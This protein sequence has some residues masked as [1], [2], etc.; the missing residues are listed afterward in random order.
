MSE[1][2]TGSQALMAQ[3]SAEG[4]EHVLTI[5]GEQS[6]PLCETMREYSQMQYLIGRHEHSLAFIANG[7]ARASN[8][9][10][11]PIVVSGPGVTDSLTPLGDA[12]QDSVPMVLVCTR[13]ENEQIGKGVL[14][15]LKD[16]S[17]LLS[18]IVKWAA[19]AESVQEVPEAVR[20]AFVQAYVGRPGP[21]VVEIPYNVQTE[22]GYVDIYPSERPAPGAADETMV[23]GVA[24]LLSRAKSPLIYAGRGAALS[25]CSDELLELVELLH[26]P[27]ITTVLGKGVLPEA[28]PLNVS[29]GSGRHGLIAQYVADA[30]TV[31]V[32][33]SSLDYSDAERFKLEFPAHLIQIDT[34]AESIGR[35]YPAEIGLIGDART[36]L[37]QLLRELKRQAQLPPP[38]MAASFSEY[39]KRKIEELR[40]AAAWQYM[41]AIQQAVSPETLIF[42][43]PARCNGWGAAFIERS[44]PNTYHCSRNFCTLGYSFSAAMGAKLAFPERQVL[45][46]IGDGGF[47][48][49]NGDLATAVQYH[50]N[51]VTIIFNDGYYGSVR[52]EQKKRYGRTFGVKLFNPD[53]CTL[54]QA[55]D[56]PA[57]R[58]ETPEQLTVALNK[59]WQVDAPMIIEVFTDPA[60]SG[61]DV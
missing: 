40:S 41:D 1:Y 52:R 6:L 51:I 45:A 22:K 15:E 23:R 56:I 50:L 48:Y 17:R 14:H 36:V 54:A 34:C 43:D 5:P 39:K 59:A 42:S 29:W 32:V 38:F 53:F 8:R 60:D 27:C 3:L 47:L 19:V 12:Y 30:D 21:T 55:F 44:L 18:S 26:A 58:V 4:V 24:E 37:K 11:V 13:A 25:G 61:F 7:Y 33:G 46:M 57:T 10:A 28:H 49:A 2:M 20:T 35:K 16:Q 9:I 31:V